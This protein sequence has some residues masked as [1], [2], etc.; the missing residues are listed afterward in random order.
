MIYPVIIVQHKIVELKTMEDGST[1]SA[2]AL[3]PTTNTILDGMAPCTLLALGTI[4][5]GSK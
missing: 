4:L 3:I 2:G 1:A 5:G